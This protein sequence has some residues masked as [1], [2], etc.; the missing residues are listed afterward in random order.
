MILKFKWKGKESYVAKII[1]KKKNKLGGLVLLDV[2]ICWHKVLHWH[3]NGQMQM[4][5]K[6]TQEQNRRLVD[7]RFI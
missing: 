2:K 5:H 6:G 1:L 4:E 7:T 3:R